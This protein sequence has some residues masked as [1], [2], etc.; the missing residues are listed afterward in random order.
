[1]LPALHMAQIHRSSY[2]FTFPEEGIPLIMH[3]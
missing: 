3:E 2:E 1:M